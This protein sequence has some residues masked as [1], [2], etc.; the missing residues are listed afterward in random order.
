MIKIDVVHQAFF[1]ALFTT[2]PSGASCLS[3]C[4]IYKVHA[5]LVGD[6]DYLTTLARLCQELFSD[7]FKFFV[8]VMVRLEW[9]PPLR[10]AST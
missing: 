6:A 10:T 5:A 4:L 3:R 9:P 1:K 2:N 7:F 8:L